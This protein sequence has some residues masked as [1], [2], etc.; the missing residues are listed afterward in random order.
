MTLPVHVVG[1][2]FLTGVACAVAGVSILNPVSFVLT[3]VGSVLP[4]IDHTKSPVGRICKPLSRY[5]NRRHGHRNLTH[6]AAFIAVLWL[7]LGMIEKTWTGQ[8]EWSMV[9][10]IAYCSHIFLDML[11][12]HGVGLFY[13]FLRNMAVLPGNSKYRVKTG[14][15]KTEAGIFIGFSVVLIGCLPLLQQ[16]FW[17]SYNRTFS[18]PMHLVSEFEKSTDL[19]Q[20]SYQVQR[21]SKEESGKGFVVNPGPAVIVLFEDGKFRKIDTKTEKVLSITPEHT[22][23]KLFFKTVR[24]SEIGLDSLHRLAGSLKVI[25][26][27]VSGSREFFAMGELRKSW[28]MN[29]LVGLWLR[30]DYQEDEFERPE[31]VSPPRLASIKKRIARLEKD[32]RIS[33]EKRAAALRERDQLSDEI[34]KT[35]DL[36]ERQRLQRKLSRTKVPDHRSSEEQIAELRSE[37][38][39]LQSDA[40]QDY[41]EKVEDEKEEWESGKSGPLAFSG[42]LDIVDFKE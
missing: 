41:S 31:Y 12:Y 33:R 35:D 24:F 25:R 22:G 19:L 8:S 4:D 14:N 34:I 28:K 38:R 42:W 32:D 15:P 23:K 10:G 37:L 39:E 6:S 18:T 2:V 1:G 9:F 3:V 7:V 5:L 30:D 20:A 36:V 27:E 16:G 21:G 17:T 26:G 29:L 11:T 13:P 40:K